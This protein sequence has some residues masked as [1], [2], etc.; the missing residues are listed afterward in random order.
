MKEETRIWKLDL[1]ENDNARFKA[2]LLVDGTLINQEIHKDLWTRGYAEIEITIRH[3][4][5]GKP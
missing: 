1:D 5:E 2:E 4:P 3:Y